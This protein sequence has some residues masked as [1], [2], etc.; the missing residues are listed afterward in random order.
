M[1]SQMAIRCSSV[2]SGLPAMA[3]TAGRLLQRLAT[4]PRAFQK[5]E[6]DVEVCTVAW[7]LAFQHLDSHANSLRDGS[8]G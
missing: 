4:L 8:N 2:A 7:M 6:A 5:L 3:T 1:Q